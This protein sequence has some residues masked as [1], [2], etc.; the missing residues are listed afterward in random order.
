MNR[1]SFKL[2]NS[3]NAIRIVDLEWFYWFFCCFSTFKIG[4]D[5]KKTW[6]RE[7]KIKAI[8]R[9]PLN[10]TLSMSFERRNDSKHTEKQIFIIYFNHFICLLCVWSLCVY[11]CVFF[12]LL[13]YFLYIFW[14][15]LCKNI[16]IYHSYAEILFSFIHFTFL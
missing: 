6:F 14:C 8:I 1:I 9:Q 13:S 2:R 16:H 7:D 11:V 4:K 12:C 5:C 10:Q 3:V 15:Y